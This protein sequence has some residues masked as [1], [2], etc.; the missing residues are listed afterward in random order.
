MRPFCL[1]VLAALMLAG[2]TGSNT[3]DED[4][5][6]QR[7]TAKSDD[8]VSFGGNGAWNEGTIEEV[9]LDCGTEARFV[10]FINGAGQL[11]ITVQDWAGRTVETLELDGSG[12]QA[13][14]EPVEGSAGRWQVTVEVPDRGGLPFEPQ[15]QF[16]GQYSGSLSC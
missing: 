2:C 4:G 9:D 12:Q 6:G 5:A 8:R 13:M 3:A 14:D 16:S 15:G 10:A 1:V 11:Q 7:G